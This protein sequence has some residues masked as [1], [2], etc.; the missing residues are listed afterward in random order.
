VTSDCECS[1]GRRRR[2]SRPLGARSGAGGEC[3][4]L[5]P[6]V[7]TWRAHRSWSPRTRPDSQPTTCTW[8]ACLRQLLGWRHTDKN[9]LD[10][11]GRLQWVLGGCHVGPLSGYPSCGTRCQLPWHLDGSRGVMDTASK[12]NCRAF[13]SRS[14]FLRRL[15]TSVSRQVEE[16]ENDA[17]SIALGPEPNQEPSVLFEKKI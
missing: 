8:R 2:G 11:R 14:L 5:R 12:R 13:I 6:V 16:Q 10:P 17:C 9:I 4:V 1:R 3:R 15:S 7:R